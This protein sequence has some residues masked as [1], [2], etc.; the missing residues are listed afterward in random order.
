MK[1]PNIYKAKFHS[2]PNRFIAYAEL[3][4]ET[5]IC[6]VKN[7]G[8]CKE[9][10]VPG[11][12]V[13]LTESDNPAR[14]TKYDLV[15]V[16]KNGELFNIDSQAPNIA[17]GE[18]LRKIYPEALI[19]PETKFGNSRFDFYIEKGEDKI[20]VEVKGVTLE[21]NGVALFPDAPTERGV[22]HIKELI[23]YAEKGYKTQILFVIQTDNVKYFAPNDET[24][25]EFGDALRMAKE[26]GVTVEAVNCTVTPD[27]MIIKDNIQVALFYK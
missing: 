20:I 24:H 23:E 26:K 15:A 9:L 22:K 16:I 4:G 1:Y 18:Y 7:T 14:K 5:V 25:K 13:Y 27:S 10:L 19:R 2:R 3:N 12:D 21:R 11:C 8:R 17:V 6:H